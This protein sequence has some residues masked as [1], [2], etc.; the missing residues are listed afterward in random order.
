MTHEE[1]KLTAKAIKLT[2]KQYLYAIAFWKDVAK[3]RTLS[4]LS[5]HLA[6]GTSLW[7]SMVHFY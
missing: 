6:P 5:I 3:E 2:K 1:G 7:S 4:S